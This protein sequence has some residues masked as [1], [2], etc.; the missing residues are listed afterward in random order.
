LKNNASWE[1][2][3]IPSERWQVNSREGLWF[4]VNHGILAVFYGAIWLSFYAQFSSI[5]YTPIG[6][7]VSA[8]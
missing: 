7:F 3:R 4:A 8:V 5:N 1:R 6:Q 2:Q